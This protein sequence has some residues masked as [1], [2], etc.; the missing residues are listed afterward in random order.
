M[1]TQVWPEGHSRQPLV[2]TRHEV[3][4]HHI[5]RGQS[6]E[7]QQTLIAFTL[8]MVGFLKSKDYFFLAQMKAIT[9]PVVLRTK[10]ET[11]DTR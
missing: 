10:T 1:G 4:P 9:H 7:E 5:W 2:L 6:H 11:N 8:K 3:G